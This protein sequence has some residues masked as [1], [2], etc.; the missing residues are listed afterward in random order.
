M[1]KKIEEIIHI[2]SPYRGYITPAKLMGPIVHP[3][4]ITKSAAVQILMLGAKVY[5]FIPSTRQT[6]EL[7]LDNINNPNRY[8]VLKTPEIDNKSINKNTPIEPVKV[9]GVPKVETPVEELVD[10]L[11]DKKGEEVDVPSGDLNEEPAEILTEEAPVA[12]EEVKPDEF[13]FTFNEDGTVDESAIDWSKFSKNERKAIRA[14]I[15]AH[16]ESIANN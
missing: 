7:T 3:L 5:E 10:T 13:E 8:D 12:P 9:K 1:P 15:T 16:N 14:K 11:K 6:L 2:L 4:K